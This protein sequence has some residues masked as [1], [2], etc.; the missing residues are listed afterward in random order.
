MSNLRRLTELQRQPLSLVL[1]DI[2]STD[3]HKSAQAGQILCAKAREFGLNVRDFLTL[4]VDVP[5]SFRE[6]NGQQINP[7]MLSANDHLSGYEAALMELNLP[8]RQDFKQGILLEAAS[9]T[10]NFKPG[11][12][13]LFPEVVDDMMRWESRLDDMES[14]DGLVAQSRTIRGTELLTRAILQDSEESRSTSM[15]AEGANIPVYDIT[16]S[17]NAVKFYKHGSAIRTTYEFERRVAMDILKPY[18]ARVERQL[19]ISKVSAAVAKLINGDAVYS[20]APVVNLSTHDADFTNGKTLKD[21]YIALMKFLVS[22]AKSGLPVDTIAGNLDM[23]LELF[24]MFN[25]TTANKSVAEHLQE[26][27]AP[28]VSLAMDLLKGVTFKLASAMPA[29]KLMC[30]SRADTLEELIEAN[31]DIRESEQAIKNQ[32]ITYV[33]TQNSGYKLVFGDTR[34]L[35]NMA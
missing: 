34:T 17:E 22:R 3:P 12:R 33:R 23:Y 11:T 35:L 26:K 6:V 32:T 19:Q 13:A 21:N 9:D 15:I 28:R 25:P 20:A 8:T 18:A 16:S 10:F 31:S 24:L 2:G 7:F 5:A 4:A 29:G 27:G 14:T 1:G 30:F